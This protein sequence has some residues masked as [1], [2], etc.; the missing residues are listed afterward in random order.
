[1][2]V[3]ECITEYFPYTKNYYSRWSWKRDFLSALTSQ[4]I[5]I[6]MLVKIKPHIVL[7]RQ[8]DEFQYF[9][10]LALLQWHVTLH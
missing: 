10:E 1:M 5:S 8:K 7:L 9:Q 4:R 2:K 3:T 6:I